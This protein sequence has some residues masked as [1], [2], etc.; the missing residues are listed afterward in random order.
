MQRYPR[1]TDTATIQG[2]YNSALNRYTRGDPVGAAD[3]IRNVAKNLSSE[4]NFYKLEATP[5][6]IQDAIDAYSAGKI[7][8]TLRVL[9]HIH[10]EM[11]YGRLTI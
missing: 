2:L 7:R 8:Y 11:H 6:T 4:V 10:L 9:K 5:G 3:T 1:F